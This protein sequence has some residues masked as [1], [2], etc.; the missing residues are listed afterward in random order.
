MF[1]IKGMMWPGTDTGQLIISEL[2]PAG[3][4]FSHITRNSG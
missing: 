3:Y 2:V 4:E 1:Y